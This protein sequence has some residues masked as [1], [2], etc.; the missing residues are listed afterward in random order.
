MLRT[1]SA[2]ALTSEGVSFWKLR[3]TA[4]AIGPKAEP[5]SCE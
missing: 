3:C 1:Y 4:W 5:R 2:I